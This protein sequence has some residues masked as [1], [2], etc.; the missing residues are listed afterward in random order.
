VRVTGKEKDRE[1]AREKDSQKE[2]ETKEDR[3]I[4]IGGKKRGL[5][6]SNEEIVVLLIC[7]FLSLAV[8]SADLNML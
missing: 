7:L 5:M 8:D 4:G 1:T 2:K 6:N 3:V